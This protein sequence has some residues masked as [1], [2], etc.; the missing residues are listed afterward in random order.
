[1]LRSCFVGLN[2]WCQSD[3]YAGMAALNPITH[4]NS[5]VLA[6]A[7]ALDPATR[8]EERLQ[9]LL[10]LWLKRYFSGAAFTTL[11]ADGTTESRTFTE[12]AMAFQEDEMAKNPQVP[13]LHLLMPD[14]RTKRRDYAD[15]LRGADDDWTIDAMVKVPATLTKTEMDGDSAEE[16]ARR[17]GSELE[18]LLESTEREALNE[19][20]ILRVKLERPSVLL[21]AG[22][23][24][25]RML[26]FSCR[27]R[28]EMAKK[29]F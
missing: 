7:L 18:W 5:T 20:G 21:P 1:M 3:N 29:R 23:W 26:V 11:K 12:C 15:N 19:V 17:V 4:A 13:M 10:Y 16:I 28:R 22:A 2:G 25:M 24:Q 14:R 9:S 27:T 6:A 8:A